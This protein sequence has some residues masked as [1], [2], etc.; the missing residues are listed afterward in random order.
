MKYV[1][2]RGGV[3]PKEFSDIVL[4][5]LASDGGL[6]M[7][8][9]YPQIYLH[10]LHSI[11]P[12]DYAKTAMIILQKFV[13]D[14][15]K[16]DLATIVEKTYTR[17]AFKSKE[18]VPVKLMFDDLWLADLSCGPTLAFKDIALQFLGNLFEYSLDRKDSYLNLL[19]ATSGDTGSSAQ[20][21]CIG[22]KRLATFILSPLEGMSDFQAA[23]MRS[24]ND[25]NT[26][27]IAVRGVFDDGQNLVKEVNSDLTFKEKYHIGAVNSIN[28]ARV[29]AQ[30]VYYFHSYPQVVKHIGDNVDF[31]IPT[32]NF[33]NIC[34]GWI[35]K[36]MG[37]P[38]RRLI[39]ATNE[40]D[41]LDEFFRTGIYQA[42][43]TKDVVQTS[44][45]SMDISNASNIERFFYDISGRDSS[46]VRSWMG[47]VKRGEALDLNET[48]YFERVKNSGIVSGRSNSEDRINMI[49]EVYD[50][51]DMIIDPHTADG[52]RVAIDHYNGNV[53]IVC[54]AT[55]KPTKFEATI[56]KA[57]EFIPSRPEEFIRIERLPQHYTTIDKGDVEGLKSYVA[58]HAI[59]ER[60]F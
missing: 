37:L 7:P 30:V 2:T 21:G 22:K 24:I 10:E 14:I 26:H 46:V 8:E 34:A 25:K 38:I 47:K 53:P 60:L 44:S 20:Q 27:N 49:R 52:V 28:W 50:A 9:K 43:N 39:L 41:V 19:G 55:A 3:E 56:Q 48:V 35:A 13:G 45:P 31:S 5:G 18:V 1:S 17:K 12:K 42:R 15:P 57:L 11:E 4:E 40:N 54:L 6:F 29:A 59:S 32:G 16:K 58:K 23:Q 33:G 36:Q 51:A